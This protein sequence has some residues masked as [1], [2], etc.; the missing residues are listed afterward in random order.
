VLG[1]EIRTGTPPPVGPER[2]NRD[3]GSPIYL[4]CSAQS[5]PKSRRK[6]WPTISAETGSN[7][8]SDELAQQ[9][10]LCN[11]RQRRSHASYI[12]KIATTGASEIRSEATNDGRRSAAVR[13][14]CSLCRMRRPLSLQ[15]T[16]RQT[17]R[18]QTQPDSRARI[19]HTRSPGRKRTLYSATVVVARPGCARPCAGCSERQD[20]RA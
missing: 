1:L 15:N 8:A 12:L 9:R 11:G 4:V 14:G 3:P 6:R 5:S 16:R 17:E 18:A 7:G 13:R 20:V 19:K 10:A 2:G